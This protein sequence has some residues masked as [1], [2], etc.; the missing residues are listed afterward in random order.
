MTKKIKRKNAKPAGGRTHINPMNAEMP[1]AIGNN[2]FSIGFRY[3]NDNLCVLK[4]VDPKVSRKVHE[5]YRNLGKCSSI[6]ETR[7]LPHDIKPITN[8]NHYT[9]YYNGLTEDVD[10]YEFDAGV[11]RGFF[12]FDTS[13]NLINMIAIDHHP[14]N[15]KHKK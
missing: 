15:Q 2:Y 3:F 10:V 8:S 7:E 9:Q 1:D 5:I 12:F 14:E 13:N 4:K 11:C 6:S